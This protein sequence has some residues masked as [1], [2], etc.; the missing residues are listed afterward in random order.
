MQACCT[1]GERQEGSHLL[2][3]PR[4][5]AD[6]DPAAILQLMLPMSYL[7]MCTPCFQHLDT[8]TLSPEVHAGQLEA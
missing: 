7:L 5:Q 4:Q 1:C 2:Q 3:W 6:P 8:H